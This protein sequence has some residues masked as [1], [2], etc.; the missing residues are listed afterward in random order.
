[1]ASLMEGDTAF[2]VGCHHLGFLLQSTYDTV[3][4]IEEILFAD[5]LLVVA[6]CDKSCLVA[7]I[8]DVS[9]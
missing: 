7:Y 8:G 1:M 2:L 5:S 9:T 3:Y 4:G 6:C